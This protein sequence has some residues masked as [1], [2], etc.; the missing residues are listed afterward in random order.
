MGE[1]YNIHVVSISRLLLYLFIKSFKYQTK[2]RCRYI[3]YDL[4]DSCLQTPSD[5]GQYAFDG[6]KKPL[7]NQTKFLWTYDKKE[8]RLRLWNM[9]I[10][11]TKQLPQQNSKLHNIP[12]FNDITKTAMSTLFN[13][14]AG[15]PIVE[16]GITKFHLL[17]KYSDVNSISLSVRKALIMWPTEWMTNRMKL[18]EFIRHKPSS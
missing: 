3:K 6:I 10:Q 8:A 7:Q 4:S 12:P 9:E 16:F 18:S 17:V 14:A 15:W 5:S 13:L 11:N 2:S 1:F